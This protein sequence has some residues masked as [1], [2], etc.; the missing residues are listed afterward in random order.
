MHQ[1]LRVA[2]LPLRNTEF[3]LYRLMFKGWVWQYLVFTV[4]VTRKVICTVRS[5]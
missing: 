1:H 4:S 5:K 3:L 2:L